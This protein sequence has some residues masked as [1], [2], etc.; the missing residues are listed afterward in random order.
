M[1]MSSEMSSKDM[2]KHTEMKGKVAL[3]EEASWVKLCS[4]L[5]SNIIY[6]LE[7]P[8]KGHFVFLIPVWMLDEKS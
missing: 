3:E 8:F 1:A 6:T 2:A 5:V 4:R 7:T